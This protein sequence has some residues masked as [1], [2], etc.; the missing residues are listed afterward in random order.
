M[1]TCFLSFPLLKI[2]D[3]DMKSNQ[4]SC[5]CVRTSVADNLYC[6]VVSCCTAVTI[7]SWNNSKDMSLPATQCKTALRRKTVRQQ[8]IK[9]KLYAVPRWCRHRSRRSK[10]ADADCTEDAD[11]TE[12]ARCVNTAFKVLLPSARKRFNTRGIT[13]H[14]LNTCHVLQ[15]VPS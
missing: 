8:R 2:C 11:R 10:I 9:T 4:Y 1:V 5:H 14:V 6:L 3:R 13:R 7:L 15:S 12:D